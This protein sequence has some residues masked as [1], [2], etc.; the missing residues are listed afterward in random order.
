MADTFHRLSSR[1]LLFVLWSCGQRAC[2]VHISTGPTRRF[3]HRS[4]VQTKVLAIYYAELNVGKLNQPI[5]SIGFRDADC[6]AD[7]NLSYEDQLAAPF[8][9][10]V[11]AHTTHRVS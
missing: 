10:A 1:F 11:R 2:V 5:T 8:Y 7:Q 6:L 3:R 9:L 4:P